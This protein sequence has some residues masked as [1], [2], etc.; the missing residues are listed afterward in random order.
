MFCDVP[1]IEHY[2][3]GDPPNHKDVQFIVLKFEFLKIILI[4]VF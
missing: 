2:T 4:Q 1:P 3:W